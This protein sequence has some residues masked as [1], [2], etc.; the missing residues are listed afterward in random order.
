[1]LISITFLIPYRFKKNGIARINKVSDT[2]EID[3]IIVDLSTTN[4]FAYSGKSPNSLK[5]K[6]PYAFVSCNAAPKNM[7]KM[8]KSAIL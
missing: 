1:M 8:K 5:N 7:A 3:I 4:D 2:C 6:S